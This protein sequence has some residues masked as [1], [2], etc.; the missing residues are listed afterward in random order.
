MTFVRKKADI[1][2]IV[3]TVFAIVNKAKEDKAVNGSENVID[4]TIG[5]LYGEDETLVALDEVFDHYDEIDHRTKAAYASSFTGNPGFRKSVYE[6]VTQGA[7]LRLHHSV[8]ATPGGSGADFMAI[9]SCLDAG[10]TLLIPDVAWGSYTLMA[11]EYNIDTLTY[12][13]FEAD[14]F[15]LNSVKERVQQLLE[16]QDRIV[17]VINDPCH[18]PTGYSLTQQEWKE[19]V[20]FIKEVSQRVAFILI[21]DIAYIDYSNDLDHSRKYMETW[22]DLS[23]NAMVVVAFSCSNTLISYGLRCGAAI[24]LNQSADAVRE[25]EIV[26]EKK[27]RATW[28]NIPNAAMENFTWLVTQDK[29]K[30]LVEKQKYIDLMAE[31]SSIFLKEAKACGLETYP[32]KEG[33]F[34]TLSIKDNDFRNRYHQALMDEHIY[35]VCVNHGIRVAVCSLPLKKVA[36]LAERM[37]HIQESTH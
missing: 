14:H 10:E 29:E 26:F 4:A 21:D 24:I 23:D 30:L 25:V 19:L 16:K 28:S 3:D 12:S 34:V 37:K 20:S 18:N 6:W 9:T 15:N 5:S 35:T 22:N 17:M 36:G 1:T 2:P 7:D 33:F 8:I 31:R 32:Y 27:A 13:M 11:H